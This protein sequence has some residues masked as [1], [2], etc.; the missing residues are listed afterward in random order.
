[1]EQNIKHKVMRMLAYSSGLQ[2]SEVVR[3]KTKYVDSIRMCLLIEQAK[4]KKDRLVNLSP[5]LLIMLR[6]YRRQYRPPRNSYL[7][8]GQ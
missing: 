7:F 4:E 1:M 5:V 6:E 2:V 8:E 3:V